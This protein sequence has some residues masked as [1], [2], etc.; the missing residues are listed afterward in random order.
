MTR[1]LIAILALAAGTA[2]A[3]FAQD[4]LEI[5]VYEYS[6]VPKGKWNLETHFN[7]SARGVRDTV[8]KI[9]P[10][11]GQTRLTFELTR[12]ITDW[13]EMAGYLAFARQPHDGPEFA[14][15]RLR[16]R[17]R[18]PDNWKFPVQ[19]SLS[20][21]VA[22]PQ[23]KY[24][25]EK[26]TLEIR[27][28]I[29]RRFGAVQVDLNPVVG[30]SLKGPGASEG[31][32]FEPGGRFAVSVT[33]TLD[34]SVE[35]YGSFGPV[36]DFLPRAEQVHLFFGGGDAQLSENVVVNFGVGLGATSVGEQTVLKMRVG[37]LF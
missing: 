20:V 29:E 36:G 31:W 10:T 27:P 17:V 1:A 34:L 9:L 28:V 8:G 25:A 30:R 15:W 16:P 19:L 37:W 3:L 35:Y 23:N 33:K 32:D 2:Q 5:Q 4:I 21:E 12:G 24:E 7:H 13:F 26:A 22:F 6:T 14:A 18:A 11:Q